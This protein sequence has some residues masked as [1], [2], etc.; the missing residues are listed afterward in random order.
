[1]ALTKV[2]TN[3]IAD[4]AVSV[5][6]YGAKGDGVTDDSAAINAAIADLGYAYLSTPDVSYY[7][8]SP[9]VLTKNQAVFGDYQGYS[10]IEY[11]GQNATI[12]VDRGIPG[13]WIK[14]SYCQVSNISIN[15]NKTDA[16]D[17]SNPL[18]V[19]ILLR[20]ENA[21]SP[22]PAANW[23]WVRLCLIDTVAIAKAYMS[24]QMEAVYRI[25]LNEINTFADKFGVAYNYDQRAYIGSGIIPKYATTMWYNNVYCRGAQSGLPRPAG[26]HGFWGDQNFG[27]TINNC[28]VE[29]YDKAAYFFNTHSGSIR[30]IYSEK[31]SQG[32]ELIGNLSPFIVDNPYIIYINPSESQNAFRSQFG[33]I[34]FIGGEVVLQGGPSVVFS[35]VDSSGTCTFVTHPT[36]SGCSFTPSLGVQYYKGGLYDDNSSVINTGLVFINE[37]PPVVSGVPLEITPVPTTRTGGGGIVHVTSYSLNTPGPSDYQALVSFMSG[38][39]NVIWQS[40][41]TGGTVV[42]STS[43]DSLY[44]TSTGTSAQ[45]FQEVTVRGI[46]N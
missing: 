36:I 19:G 46:M 29:N 12:L 33:T 4:T 8:E 13:V 43:G 35:P 34:V 37:F 22:T 31:C 44:V 2:F 40:N 14:D 5:K 18:D 27:L 21:F 9:I 23:D 26:G 38:S 15:F 28:A 30:N 16:G 6:S 10:E 25:S 39:A 20:A 17:F 11:P 32:F 24:I 3:M 41:N 45:T 1:M 42:Y 7:I